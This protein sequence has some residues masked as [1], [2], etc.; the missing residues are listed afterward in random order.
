MSLDPQEDFP[1]L[2]RLKV[3]KT[4]LF[5]ALVLVGVYLVC[6]QIPLVECR[7]NFSRIALAGFPGLLPLSWLASMYLLMSMG[8]VTASL[9]FC[10][11]RALF[12]RNG[13]LIF[14]SE[15]L[16]ICPLSSITSVRIVRS[17]FGDERV[18]LITMSAKKR[19]INTSLLRERG[20][21]VVGRIRDEIA[22]MDGAEA[23]KVALSE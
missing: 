13:K 4:L 9:I 15:L 22:L 8:L 10:G 12:L 1:V 20:L 14:I 7:G 18:E 16:F 5:M 23:H 3:G 11:S 21:E 19:Y 17:A 6:V 2:A